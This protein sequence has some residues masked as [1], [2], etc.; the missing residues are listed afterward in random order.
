MATK[1]MFALSV[2]IVLALSLTGCCNKTADADGVWYNPLT[3]FDSK[4]PVSVAPANGVDYVSVPPIRAADDCS[5]F[6]KKVAPQGQT[7]KTY[8]TMVT[9]SDVEVK[10]DGIWVMQGPGGVK[11][12]STNS[13]VRCPYGCSFALPKQ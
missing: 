9:E 3:W 5:N 12:L 6:F 11:M 4:A 1:K 13:E 7:C 10:I 8:T 2:L